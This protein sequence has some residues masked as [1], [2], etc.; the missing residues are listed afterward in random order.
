MNKP[1]KLHALVSIILGIVTG[2]M[3]FVLGETND[4]PGMCAIGVALGFILVMVGAVQAGIIKK[5]LLVPIILLFFSIFATML[6]IALLAEGEFGS[7]P[8]IS[9]IGFGLAIV[10]LLIG[11]QKILV[12]RKSN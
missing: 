5:R 4:A 3:L 8:W 10:L 1:K 6:T 7:Q 12:F 9:S 11:L 2:G